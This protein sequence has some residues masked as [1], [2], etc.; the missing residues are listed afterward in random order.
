MNDCANT[1]NTKL[2]IIEA[3]D[4]IECLYNI[5]K[6]IKDGEEISMIISDHSM[7]FMIGTTC[8]QIL[9]ELFLKNLNQIPF[10]IL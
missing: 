7:N 6:S 5:Y 2:N 10:H 8:E 1:L 9:N 3:E 4:G